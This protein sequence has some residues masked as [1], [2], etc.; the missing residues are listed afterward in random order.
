MYLNKYM[1]TRP[2]F[3]ILEDRDTFMGTE[4]VFILISLKVKRKK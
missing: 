1:K 2:T 3:S 4:N